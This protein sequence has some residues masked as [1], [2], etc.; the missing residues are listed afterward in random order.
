[1]KLTTKTLILLVASA[2]S[3]QARAERGWHK[4]TRENCAVL[5]GHLRPKP[6][7]VDDI[8]DELDAKSRGLIKDCGPGCYEY[9]DWSSRSIPARQ[10]ENERKVAAAYAES[11]LI[12]NEG[13]FLFSRYN[14]FDVPAWDGLTF[15]LDTGVITSKVSLK[16]GKEAFLALEHAFDR[17]HRYSVHGGEWAN[18]AANRATRYPPPGLT[19]KQARDYSKDNFEKIARWML[20]DDERVRTRV[21]LQQPESRP[22]P[23]D[24]PVYA[25]RLMLSQPSPE[26]ES[27]I[28]I[29]GEVFH[30]IADENPLITLNR[31]RQGR[32]E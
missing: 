12:K 24:L 20:A 2:C 28:L 27:V 17:A 6:L 19:W 25:Q 9:E 11:L 23:E 8:I 30:R 22:M 14:G 26:I 15:E 3:V 21:V 32:P 13:L 31:S 7:T 10:A 29:D 4:L 16:R 18:L 5:L 1:M